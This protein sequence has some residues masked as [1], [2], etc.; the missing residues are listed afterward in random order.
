MLE[1]EGGTPVKYIVGARGWFTETF[2]RTRTVRRTDRNHASDHQ[3]SRSA[4]NFIEISSI[5]YTY[6]VFISHSS[7]YI[8]KDSHKVGLEKKR[9]FKLCGVSDVF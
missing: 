9:S 2:M 7:F 3:K 5:L 8:N 4:H 1:A 6:L